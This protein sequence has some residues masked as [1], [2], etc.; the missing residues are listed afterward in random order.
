MFCDVPLPPSDAWAPAPMAVLTLPAVPAA[1]AALPT[2]VLFPAPKGVLVDAL[3]FAPQA[4][5]VPTPL[6]FAAVAP[7]PVP[8]AVSAQTNCAAASR[9]AS[10]PFA[11]TINTTPISQ[12]VACRLRQKFRIA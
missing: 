6:G 8:L 5:L 11:Q 9:G 4:K 12:R 1:F 10:K 7:W 2:A 3:A